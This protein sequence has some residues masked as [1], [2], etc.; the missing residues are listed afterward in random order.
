MMEEKYVK[1]NG[2]KAFLLAAR[3]KTL[4]GAAVPVMI[5]VAFAIHDMGWGQ[6]VTPTGA[7]WLSCPIVPALLCFLFAFAMQ[8]DA[9]FVNDYFDYVRGGDD[10]ATRLGPRRAC[11]EGWITLPA[12][13]IALVITT[14]IAC[15]LGLPLVAYG[16][17]EMIL[18][19]LACVVFCF[20]YTT[21]FAQHGLGDVL[22]LVFFGIIPVSL[23]Y[24]VTLSGINQIIPLQVFFSS[25]ACGVIIDTLLVVNNYRDIDNDRQTGKNTLI[26]RI[27]QHGGE[28]LYVYLGL[29]GALMIVNTIL[30]DSSGLLPY[31][32]LGLAFLPYA[33]LHYKA[34]NRMK[35]IGKGRE[36][37]QVLAMT[38]RNILVFGVT[39]AL[40]ILFI[41]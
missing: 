35:A 12:M 28:Y 11:A 7:T 9:N 4:S 38:A 21:L 27:G 18:V 26:V 22:V 37:N 31:L 24:Y 39:S 14:A 6:F 19:G 34:Y 5:G 10:R 17:W 32:Y 33:I 2:A 1:V 13:R 15:L 25:I 40:A 3:P 20:L 30:Y 29:L 36:L 16:G 8:V 23:T 41:A